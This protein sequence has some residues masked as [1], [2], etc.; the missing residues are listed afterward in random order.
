VL[1]SLRP[2]L[3]YLDRGLVVTAVPRGEGFAMNAPESRDLNPPYPFD[4]LYCG[5]ETV[6]DRK[7]TPAYDVFSCCAMLLFLLTRRPPFAGPSLMHQLAA[8]QAGPPALP[9]A[10]D[11]RTAELV[12]RGLSPDPK[13]RPTARELAAAVVVS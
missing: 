4:G 5:P 7:A 2:E 11:P 8:M 9:A 1:Y 10:L 13:Q 6:G 12:R 3:V